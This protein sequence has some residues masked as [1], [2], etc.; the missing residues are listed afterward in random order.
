MAKS[1]D[2]KSVDDAETQDDVAIAG[3][4]WQTRDA[5]R[6]VQMSI[7]APESVYNQFRTVCQN[8][9]RTNGEMLEKLLKFYLEKRTEEEALR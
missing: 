9:R 4:R 3:R 1:L 6:P 5:D 8:E 7:R 2:F